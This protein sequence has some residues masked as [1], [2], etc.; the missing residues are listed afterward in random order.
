MWLRCLRSEFGVCLKLCVCMI[1]II[2][3]LGCYCLLRKMLCVMIWWWVVLII[4]GVNIMRCWKR[5]RVWFVCVMRCILLCR[6]C[7]RVWVICFGLK[8]VRLCGL[9]WF[10]LMWSM[11]FL[12]WW[13]SCRVVVIS[14]IGWCLRGF[15]LIVCGVCWLMWL[16]DW[17]LMVFCLCVLFFLG[18]ISMYIWLNRVGMWLSCCLI[19]MS[20]VWVG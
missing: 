5:V 12:L 11:G 14:C 15:C 1:I 6:L 4:V 2:D 3:R 16:S 8:L 10:W 7:L 13:F 19:L 18:I 9:S 17:L 20:G